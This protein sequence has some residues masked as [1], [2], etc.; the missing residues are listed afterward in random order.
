MHSK[1]T[2]LR[3]AAAAAIVGSLAGTT[4]GFLS[5]PIWPPAIAA[6]A[7]IPLVEAVVA[8]PA[9]PAV[10]AT[11]STLSKSLSSVPA[12]RPPSPAASDAANLLHRAEELARRPDVRG[13]LA[14]REEIAQR[15]ASR[16]QQGSA[17]T[18][19]Q[20]DETDRYLSEARALQLQRDAQ[21]LRRSAGIP[22]AV[23]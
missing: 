5:V 20:L 13:L 23:H 9:A 12:S 6:S 19:R 17:E 8:S 1:N 22:A 16:G 4:A 15:A 7:Q 3:N 2:V 14:L 11:P 21:E 18:R 10:P